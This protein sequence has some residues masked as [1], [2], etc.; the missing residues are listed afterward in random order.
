MPFGSLM[1]DKI[2]VF[3]EHGNLVVENEAASVQNG[4]KSIYEEC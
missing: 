2:S 1:K 3:D 4:K